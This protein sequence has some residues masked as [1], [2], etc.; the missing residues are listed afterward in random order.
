M[1]DTLAQSETKIAA[2]C[3]AMPG[4]YHED[5]DCLFFVTELSGWQ[6]YP[7]R[8]TLTKGLDLPFLV[9]NDANASVRPALVPRAGA[10]TQNMLYV[11]AGRGRGLRQSSRRGAL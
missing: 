9:V 3:M 6:N 1:E 8:A 2:A 11:L 7:I 10:A 5:R 4:P